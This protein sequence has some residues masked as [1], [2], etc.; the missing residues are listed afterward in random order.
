MVTLNP[1]AG[2]MDYQ[3]FTCHD[4][5]GVAVEFGDRVTMGTFAA[6]QTPATVAHNTA[7]VDKYLSFYTETLGLYPP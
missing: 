1:N 3:V 4:P 6:P 2:P 5:D 7:N